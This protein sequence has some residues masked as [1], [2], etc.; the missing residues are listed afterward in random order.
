VDTVADS[1]EVERPRNTVKACRALKESGGTSIL[2]SDK[3]ILKAQKLLGSTEG[4]YAEPAGASPIAGVKKALANGTIAPNEKV[5]VVV[6]GTGLKDSKSA[7]KAADEMN[8]ID[9]DIQSVMERYDAGTSTSA[10]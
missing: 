8:S 9:P 7:L 5:V 2:V 6:T 3:E 1:I 10:T 4:I